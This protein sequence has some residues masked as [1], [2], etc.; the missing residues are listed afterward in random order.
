DQ[1]RPELTSNSDSSF[2]KK[3][4]LRIRINST[5]EWLLSMRAK[6]GRGAKKVSHT[7]GATI[8]GR[9]CASERVN[10]P[11]R[12]LPANFFGEMRPRMYVLPAKRRLGSRELR[13]TEPYRNEP[14]EAGKV[15]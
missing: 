3:K 1:C 10:R 9:G 13:H 5:W 11:R 4:L 8:A 7:T 12:S 15:S 6:L 14:D 2:A